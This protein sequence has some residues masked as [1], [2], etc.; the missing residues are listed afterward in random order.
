MDII[1]Y[2]GKK[3]FEDRE[4]NQTSVDTIKELRKLA[5]LVF[6]SQGKLP[7]MPNKDADDETFQKWNANVNRALRTYS[8][9][10]LLRHIHH[11]ER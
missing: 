6:K 4:W 7:P 11:M 9:G 8:V 5:N 10:G 1:K 2:T 3:F